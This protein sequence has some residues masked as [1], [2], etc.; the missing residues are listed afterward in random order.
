MHKNMY[1]L[2]DPWI[3]QAEILIDVLKKQTKGT[4]LWRKKH[5]NNKKKMKWANITMLHIAYK[6]TVLRLI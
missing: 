2:T 5:A 6:H 1:D 3:F 4:P